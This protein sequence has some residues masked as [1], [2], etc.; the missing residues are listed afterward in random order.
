MKRQEGGSSR[1][2]SGKNIG[3]SSKRREDMDDEI[4]NMIQYDP[5]ED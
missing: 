5:Y 2:T 3:S 4:K 1:I